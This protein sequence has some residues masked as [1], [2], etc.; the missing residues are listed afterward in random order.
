MGGY[1]G[2]AGSFLI[3][4][5]FDLYIYVVM[6]RFLLQLV[7]ADFYNPISRV[8][9]KVSDPPL[10]LFRRYIPGLLGIDMSSIILALGLT[11]LKFF[12][13][14]QI[15]GFQPAFFGLLVYSIG[16]VLLQLSQ[17]FYYAVLIRII[18]SWVAPNSYNPAVALVHSL[19]EPLMAP[20]R[21]LIPS[22]GGLDMSP[23]VVFIILIL[24]QKILIQPVLDVGQVLM[25]G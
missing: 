6:L 14:W 4:I 13:L 10:Q 18:L 22:F 15:Q 17:I 8:I 3:G 20:A 1:L 12:L 21:R 11:I 19:T 23:I 5:I 16:D 7:H 9:V 25:Q 2:N 24:I